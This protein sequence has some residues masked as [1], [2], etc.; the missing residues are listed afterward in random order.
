[1]EIANSVAG[2]RKHAMEG[3]ARAKEQLGNPNA[4]IWQTMQSITG[5]QKLI[6]YDPDDLIAFVRM[7]EFDYVTRLLFLASEYNSLVAGFEAYSERRDQLY[8]MMTPVTMEGLVGTVVLDEEG[9]RRLRPLIATVDDMGAQMLFALDQVYDLT[10]TAIMD[11]GPKA[12]QYFEDPTFPVPS[13]VRPD[14][15][16]QSASRPQ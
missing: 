2:Y 7:R 3:I 14:I 9:A 8:S 15:D 6:E 12:R 13:L 5:L 4:P 11:F 1:M 10:V 16:Q